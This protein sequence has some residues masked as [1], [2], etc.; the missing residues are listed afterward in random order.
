[1]SAASHAIAEIEAKKDLFIDLATK[2]WENPEVANKE[3]K[4][5]A[6]TAELLRSEGFEVQEAYAGVPTAIRATYGQGSPVIGLLGE[7]DALPGMSQSV[8]TS[9]EPIIEGGAGQG[10]G[11]NLLGAAHAAAAV[12]I[13]REMQE[14]GIQGTIVFYGCPAEEQL[15]GKPFMAR[16]GGFEGL[17]C[18]FAWHP[19]T[20]NSLTLGTMTAINAARFH[21]KGVTAHAGADPQNGRSALDAAE[22]MNVGANFLREHVTHDVRIHYVITNAGEAPN[23]VPDKATNWYYVRALT[24]EAV[25][26]TF[27]RIVKVAQGAAM[28]TE[29]EVEVEDSGGCYNTLQNKVLC[30]VAYEAMQEIG[31]PEY[32]EDEIA[33]AKELNE[34]SPN[35][36][37]MVNSGRIPEG[38]HIARNIL[39]ISSDNVYASTD[40]GDVQHL[41]PG[42]SFSSTTSNVGAGGHSWQVTACSGHSIGMKGMINAAKILALSCIKV[43]DSPETLAKAKEEFDEATKGKPYV[44]PIPQGMQVP[45]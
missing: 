12:G 41:A 27:E 23:I 14:R 29:T 30:E 31:M 6:W 8:S 32:S 36:Q 25:V 10:C 18:S 15:T 13:K 2:I 19:G 7:Y 1:M 45:S 5:A 35:Y 17:D 16:D 43:F 33:F 11:H 44:C 9:K 28:M 22:L 3:H 42:A 39:P 20:A 40:V 38:E 4:A 21:F 26:S 24:R 34:A 37:M